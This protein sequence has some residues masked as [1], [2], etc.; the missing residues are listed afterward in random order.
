MEEV[1][2]NNATRRPPCSWTFQESE[3]KGGEYQDDS[4]IHHQ[5][6]PERVSEEQEIY[7]DDNR[8]QQ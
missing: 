1:G 2:A 7:S 3:V 4:Y 6:F 5:P 8:C